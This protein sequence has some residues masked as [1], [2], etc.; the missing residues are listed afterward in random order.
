MQWDA[1]LEPIYVDCFGDHV[2]NELRGARR[3][4]RGPEASQPSRGDWPA[5]R[6]LFGSVRFVLIVSRPSH[7]SR[8]WSCRRLSGLVWSRAAARRGAREGMY[9]K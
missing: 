1:S 9:S 7:A 8:R 6:Q 4:R 2:S 3:A 5:F